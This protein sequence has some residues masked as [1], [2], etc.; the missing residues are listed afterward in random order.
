[1]EQRAVFHHGVRA[2]ITDTT[3]AVLQLGIEVSMVKVALRK[4]LAY[5]RSFLLPFFAVDATLLTLRFES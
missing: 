1:M 2:V 3:Q 5:I 4:D